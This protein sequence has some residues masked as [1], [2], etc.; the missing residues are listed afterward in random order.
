[1]ATRKEL[2]ERQRI[3]DYPTEKELKLKA[4]TKQAR[5]KPEAAMHQF[6]ETILAHDEGFDL[7]RA[8]RQ[9]AKGG[10]K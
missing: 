9:R 6:V 3:E 8:I 1:M 10:N 7:F 2:A 4:I 5:N